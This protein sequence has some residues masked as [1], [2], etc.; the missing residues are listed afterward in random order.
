[1]KKVLLIA[2]K[3]LLPPDDAKES[4][5]D[6]FKTPWAAEYDVVQGLRGL[7]IRSRFLALTRKY[8]PSLKK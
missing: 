5:V 8:R 7:A 3:S 6:R 1:M 4:D 2:H